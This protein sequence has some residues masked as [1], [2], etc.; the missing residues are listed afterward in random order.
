MFWNIDW[1]WTIWRLYFAFEDYEYFLCKD[2]QIKFQL[3][4]P[5]AE[6]FSNQARVQKKG[7]KGENIWKFGQKCIKFENIL[8][9]G[10]LMRA[11]IASMKQLEYALQ[12]FPYDGPFLSADKQFCCQNHCN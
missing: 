1:H 9:K 4:K 12:A 8:K 3:T 2:S 7:K 5:S 10:S 6:E 11:T